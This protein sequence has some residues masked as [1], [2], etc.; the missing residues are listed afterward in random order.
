MTIR[1]KLELM[2]VKNGMFESQAKEVMDIAISELIKSVDVTYYEINFNRNSN[3]YPEVLYSVL[4]MSIKPI[5]LK[6]IEDNKPMAWF[7]PMFE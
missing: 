1:E 2:L 7:K 6:W 3:E 4:Y 5:A